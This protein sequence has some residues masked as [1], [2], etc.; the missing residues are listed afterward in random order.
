MRFAQL[1]RN[2]AKLVVT[3]SLPLAQG[4]RSTTTALHVAQ[5]IRRIA[6]RKKT[7][8]PHSGTN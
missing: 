6:Y 8:I 3:R 7:T 5:E 2:H 4:T 1:A